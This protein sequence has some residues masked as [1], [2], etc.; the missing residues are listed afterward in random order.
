MYPTCLLRCASIPQLIIRLHEDSSATKIFNSQI[1]K[2]GE[3][4][5][6]WSQHL[7]Q[8]EYFLMSKYW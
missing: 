4:D 2:K 5:W 3:D 6:P 7:M 1:S 8:S